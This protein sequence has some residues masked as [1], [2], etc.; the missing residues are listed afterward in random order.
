MKFN[1]HKT[2]WTPKASDRLCSEHFKAECF[3]PNVKTKRLYATAIP[4]VF[5]HTSE[6]K[7]PSQ[8]QVRYE[9]N[10]GL[11]PVLHETPSTSQLKECRAELYKAKKR[12]KRLRLTVASLKTRLKEEVKLKESLLHRLDMYKGK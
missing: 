2:V 4:T 12:E 11:V 7:N 9:A 1:D 3:N 10:Y 6:N 5:A 8:R